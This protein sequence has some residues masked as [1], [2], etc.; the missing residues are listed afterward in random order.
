MNFLLKA[1]TVIDPTSPFHQQKV[2]ILI[3]NGTIAA[4]DST[5]NTQDIVEEVILDNLHVSQ[6]WFD[7]SISFGEPGYEERETIDHG[8]QVAAKSGFTHIAVQPNTLPVIDTGAAIGYLT[9]K[10]Q[11]HAVTLHPI[12]ALTTKSAGV[13]MAELYDMQQAGAIGFGDY[14]KA[15][16]NPNLLKIALLYT[17]NFDGLVLSFPQEN[18]IAGNGV[19]NEGKEST[20]LGLKGI[21]ALAEELQIIRD[22]SLLEY[23][24][25]KLH[26]PT[27]STSKSV[28]LIREA[29]QKGLQVSCSVTAHHL[30][31]SD[32]ELH[33][34]DSN[35]KVLPPLRTQNDIDALIK[36]VKDGTIDMITSDHQPIDIEHKKVEFDSASYGTTG[37]ESAF[38]CINRIF[39]TEKA[40]EIL[41]RG[42]Q[43]FNIQEFSIAEGNPAN[44][45]LFNPDTSYT[46]S[47]EHVISTSKNSAFINKPMKGIVY[48]IVANG[49]MITA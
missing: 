47:K 20:L 6:G 24:G 26:I 16:E 23:T 5:I 9:H 31:L 39:N 42:K 27:I 49:K 48:G 32:E 28:T 8:L 22:L 33:S 19:M 2:D 43:I 4:I 1:A 45:S 44:L 7:S 13:D 34:F 46:F 41:T 11:N 38:G 14:Q 35:Y 10:T 37:L 15:I 17:Q 40:I 29:K 25:G 12:G 30:T 21:P 18:K 36:G 3:K